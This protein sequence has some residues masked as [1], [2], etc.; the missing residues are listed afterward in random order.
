MSGR[1]IPIELKAHFSQ[2]SQN[3][4]RVLRIAPRVSTIAPFGITT[5]DRNVDYDDGD[6]V[7]TYRARRG[8]VSSSQVA[9]SDLSVDNSEAEALL[10]EYPLDGVTLEM[11]KRGDLDDADYDEYLINY[12]DLVPGR[13]VVVGH[14]TIGE[15]RAEK[16][17]SAFIE[18]RSLT[19]TLKQNSIVEL[20]SVGCTTEF[21]SDRCKFP[22]D[23]LWT[24]GTVASV[25]IET[26]RTFSFALESS[27][28]DDPGGYVPGLVRFLDGDNA[29]RTFEVEDFE[30]DSSGIATVTLA[31]PTDDPITIG[32][33]EIREDCNKDWGPNGT[34]LQGTTNNCLFFSNRPNF[35]GQPHRP[36][37]DSANLSVPGGSSGGT[38]G[39]GSTQ[40]LSDE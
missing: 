4:T 23:T 29:G 15:I 13:H 7:I 30:V 22:V 32:D 5:L 27:M 35:R 20:G 19:N 2:P 16:G 26:D 28:R 21:G 25:G 11:I 37:A 3:W 18:L 40:A 9:T 14:G 24:T 33:F 39:T 36:V 12:K 17:L 10:A 31:Y 6:G 34:D 8:Y 1:S 38:S